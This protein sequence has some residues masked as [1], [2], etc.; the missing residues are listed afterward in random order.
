[1]IKIVDAKGKKCPLP[2]ILTKKCIDQSQVGD[3]IEV[4]LDNEISKCNLVQYVQELG[5]EAQ[6]QSNG[7][8]TIVRFVL[9]GKLPSVGVE[10]IN[11]PIPSKIELNDY[12]IVFGKDQMGDGE[13]ELGETLIR[14]YINTLT[15]LNTYP[16][17]I[18]FYNSG[19]KL[20]SQGADTIESLSK[21]AGFGVEILI[22]GVCVD[23]YNIKIAVGSISNMFAIGNVTA[24]ASKV[25]YP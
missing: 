1:M 11:C 18:I 21:L 23:Y 19:V 3:V 17:K 16:R 5:I 25:I 14:T 13:R 6:E 8:Q 24:S 10:D 4:I 9:G 22:C 12:V 15:E 7:D 20:V 2:I